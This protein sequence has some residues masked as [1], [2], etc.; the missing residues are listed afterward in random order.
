VAMWHLM[1][2]R[3]KPVSISRADGIAERP[4]EGVIRYVELNFGAWTQEPATNPVGMGGVEWPREC[5]FKDFLGCAGTMNYVAH[6]PKPVIMGA[7]GQRVY[8][9]GWV[10]DTCGNQEVG[11][12]AVADR[13]Y[14]SRDYDLNSE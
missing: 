11:G 8:P 2:Q 14:T 9:H 13:S 5:V 10:C 1:F 7:T 3:D 12:F 6:V 4:P